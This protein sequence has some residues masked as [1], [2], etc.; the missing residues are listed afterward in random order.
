M[1]ILSITHT[2]HQL[3]SKIILTNNVKQLVHFTA[4]FIETENPVRNPLKKLFSSEFT[5]LK[6]VT[7]FKHYNYLFYNNWPY[8]EID[9]IYMLNS[10]KM[11]NTE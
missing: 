1:L 8:D 7:S 6:Q 9:F 2:N 4:T 11:I 5:V 10:G 3:T